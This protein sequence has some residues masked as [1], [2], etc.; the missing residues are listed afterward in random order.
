MKMPEKLKTG[1]MGNLYLILFSLLAFVFVFGLVAR[2]F[3]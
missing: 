3:E 2:F 1:K